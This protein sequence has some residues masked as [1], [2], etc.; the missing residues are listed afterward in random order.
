M[1]R[2]LLLVATVG[3]VSGCGLGGYVACDFRQGSLNGPEDRCQERHGLSAPAFK[4]AC[5]ASGGTPTDGR[6]PSANVV[7]GCNLG[8]QGD[9][10]EVLDW[11]YTPMTVAQAKSNC[12][13]MT[14]LDSYK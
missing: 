3:C 14:F 2:L 5:T 6:C 9:G 7:G 12:G 11:Y 10:T 13:N 4:G 8:L 1:K